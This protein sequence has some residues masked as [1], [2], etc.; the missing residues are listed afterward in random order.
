MKKYMEA[1]QNGDLT[2]EM[3]SKSQ[4]D[5]KGSFKWS[6]TPSVGFNLT[7][8]SRSDGNTYFEDLIFYVKV[9]FGVS[10]EQTIE[11][12]I[13]LSILISGELSGDITGIYHMYTDYQDSYETEGAI[14]YTSEDFAYLRSSTAM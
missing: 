7:L 8:S 13:G 3:P 11:L 6:V 1:L 14:P 9:G 10:A 5:T 2:G 12:P 4:Y